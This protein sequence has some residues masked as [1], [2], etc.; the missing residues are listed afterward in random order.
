[1][2]PIVACEIEVGFW[3]NLLHRPH[4]H[5]RHP[6]YEPLL[7][8]IMAS[9]GINSVGAFFAGQMIDHCTIYQSNR[10]IP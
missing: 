9:N 2:R 1:M 10:K 7:W 6:Y 3:I 5:L 8:F 4:L